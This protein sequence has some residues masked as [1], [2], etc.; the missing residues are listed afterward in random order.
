MIFDK[1]GFIRFAR[2][3]VKF[4]RSTLSKEMGL[5]LAQSVGSLSGFGT[6]AI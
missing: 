2:I 1:R 5:K 3:L 6:T 4:F